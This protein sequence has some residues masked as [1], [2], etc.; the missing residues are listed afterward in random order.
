[1]NRAANMKPYMCASSGACPA[2][3]R[4][5]YIKLNVDATIRAD[6]KTRTEVSAPRSSTAACR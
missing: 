2:P 6:I 4:K 5:Q 3:T 1:M